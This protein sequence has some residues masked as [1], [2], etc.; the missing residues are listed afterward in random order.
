M[1]NLVRRRE[2]KKVF[3]LKTIWLI[4][5][6]C[7]AWP[8]CCLFRV[9][10]FITLGHLHQTESS[11]LLRNSSTPSVCSSLSHNPPFVT[12]QLATCGDDYNVMNKGLW[13]GVGNESAG[14]LTAGQEVPLFNYPCLAIRNW[15]VGTESR[16][17]RCSLTDEKEIFG[18][19]TKRTPV[20]LPDFTNID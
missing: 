13:E 19:E 1:E 4:D 8:S 16:W 20:V 18:W 7:S 10:S 6:I 2:R 17:G 11:S 5:H 3:H 15:S 9:F 14:V 12:S